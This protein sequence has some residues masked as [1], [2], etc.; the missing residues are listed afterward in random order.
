MTRVCDSS[1]INS[2]NLS[3]L[4][5]AFAPI[6]ALLRREQSGKKLSLSMISLSLF[7]SLITL[8]IAEEPESSQGL[9]PPFYLE[10]P[11]EA[12]LDWRSRGEHDSSSGSGNSCGTCGS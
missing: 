2:L 6:Q 8:A 1:P 11:S 5:G 7:F 12:A 9:I 3:L 4:R 10:P